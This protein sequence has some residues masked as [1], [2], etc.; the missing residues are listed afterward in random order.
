MLGDEWVLALVCVLVFYGA[1]VH[2]GRFGGNNHGL[3]WA[4][5]PPP[6][7]G[8]ERTDQR[9]Q[10]IVSYVQQYPGQSQSV[11][12]RET[13]IR[14]ADVIAVYR[15]VDQQAVARLDRFQN[16]RM[17]KENAGVVA[18]RVLIVERKGLAGLQIDLAFGKLANAQLGTLQVSENTDRA[19]ATAFDGANALNDRT[20]HIMAGMAHVDAEQ[21][22]AGFMKLLD[23]LLRR[24]GR[25]ERGEDFDFSVAS[26]QFWLS[27][28]PGVSES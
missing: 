20:H 8:E 22:C 18:G 9:T 23:H 10:T 14:P 4:V 5:N 7:E 17:R 1:G 6:D 11:I 26:H 24:G 3:L 19:A 15:P 21:V 2:E 12:A 16:F 13:G 28:L 25:P 27:W